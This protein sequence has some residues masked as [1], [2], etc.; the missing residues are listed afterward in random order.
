[1]T[2]CKTPLLIAVAFAVGLLLGALLVGWVGDSDS[3]EPADVSA[4]TLYGSTAQKLVQLQAAVTALEKDVAKLKTQVAGLSTSTTT[5]RPTTTT[6]PPTTTATTKPQTTTTAKPT[7]TLPPTTSTT[8]TS[9]T[10]T[11]TTTT[12]L[13]PTTSTS[14]TSTSTTVPGALN[15]RDYGAKADG[16]TDDTAA[17]QR[18]IDACPTGGTVSFP[19]GTYAINSTVYLR[20]GITITGAGTNQT[21]LV[22]PRKS[23]ATVMRTW[24]GNPV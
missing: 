19:A 11:S 17:I 6:K 21:V 7:T 13:P 24:N 15:V 16:V 5:V 23:A 3:P 2:R 18:A 9:T 4:L 22:M 10:S 14:T 12:T 1:M 20:S 8:T